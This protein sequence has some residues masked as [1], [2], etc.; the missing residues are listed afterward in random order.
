[1]PKSCIVY[2]DVDM[3]EFFESSMHQMIYLRHIPYIYLDGEGLAAQRGNLPDRFFCGFTI[4]IGYDEAGA[5]LGECDGDFLPYSLLPANT[6]VSKR[7]SS[8]LA[9]SQLP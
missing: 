2:H 1:M 9:R 4:Y 6:R 8:S 5:G 3:L 7:L